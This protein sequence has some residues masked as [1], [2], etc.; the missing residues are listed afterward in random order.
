MIS[1][2]ESEMKALSKMQLDLHSAYID[3]AQ[4]LSLL[5]KTN[6]QLSA[7]LVLSLNHPHYKMVGTTIPSDCSCYYMLQYRSLLN[8][9]RY[10]SRFAL[11]ISHDDDVHF[12]VQFPT[13]ED[14]VIGDEESSIS[15]KGP[16]SSSSQTP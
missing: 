15:L 4:C 14:P 5:T 12:V 3:Y 6:Q 10:A 1:K 8:N 16:S 2:L 13:S 9:T 7:K 11:H